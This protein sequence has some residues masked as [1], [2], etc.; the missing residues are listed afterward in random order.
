MNAAYAWLGRVKNRDT[1]KHWPLVKNPQLL[2]YSYET[3]WKWLPDEFIIFTNFHGD[4]PKNVD[5]LSITNFWTCLV[6]FTQT[7]LDSVSDSGIVHCLKLWAI[8]TCIDPKLTE[9]ALALVP[10]VPWHQWILKGCICHPWNFALF[11]NTIVNW[12]PWNTFIHYTL[13]PTFSNI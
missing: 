3:L 10:W 5:F 7:L 13:A 8:S 12:H 1:F 6:F 9:G 4:R 2:L 11:V